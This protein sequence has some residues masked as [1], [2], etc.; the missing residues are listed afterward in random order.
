MALEPSY[1]PGHCYEVNHIS[2][3]KALIVPVCT[4]EMV[5]KESFMRQNC[6]IIKR[7]LKRGLGKVPFRFFL[8]PL[9]VVSDIGIGPI[10]SPSSSSCPSPIPELTND[11]P[12]V[13]LSFRVRLPST[14][15]SSWLIADG[16]T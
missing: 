10:S 2:V 8:T 14:E 12:L 6:E 5:Q 11:S 9:S 3:H 7:R 16:V 15:G 13:S 1:L 4:R